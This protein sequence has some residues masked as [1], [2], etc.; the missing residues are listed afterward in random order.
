M[1]PG[2]AG[3]AGRRARTRRRGCS[4][5][6][7]RST[8]APPSSRPRRRT[9]TRA[10]SAQ[11]APRGR[12]RRPRQRDDPGL[13][14]QPHR[15]G[16]RVRLLLRA[17][18]DD[19]A[20]VGPRRGDGQLQP[21]DGLHRLRHLRPALLRAADPRGRAR[22]DRDRAAR[23]RDRPV[24]RPDAA[25]AGPGPG[26]RRR[27]AA[28]HPGRVDPPGRGPAQ[29]RRPA[30]RAGPDGAALR[31]GRRRPRRRWRRPTSVGY[32]LLVRPSYVLGGRAM[33]I[34]YD[35][36]GLADYLAPH[37][38]RRGRDLPRPLPG[39]RDRDRRRRAVRRR[40][41]ADRRDH[42]ARRGG[43][44][45]LRRLGLRDPGDVA[46][47]RDARPGRAG[48]RGAGHARWASSA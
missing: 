44:H 10:G 38:P 46:G 31:G 33:E 20:R 22:R 26:R 2:R 45:P 19:R 14:P 3:A 39:E 15:P 27:A 24:R 1:V 36:D 32:P 35:R 13:G 48:H 16:D 29:L 18:R 28:G 12:P 5:R 40:D 9:S 17:R 23:G 47:P 7:R 30:R 25:E 6:S 43:R 34:C 41:R 42:A 21:G 8:P 4:A 11:A 37:R